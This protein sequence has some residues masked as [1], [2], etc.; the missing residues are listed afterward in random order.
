MERLFF[1]VNTDTG[2]WVDT[3]QA[4]SGEVE[5]VSWE[6]E[7]GDTGDDL[8][9]Y[10]RPVKSDTGDGVRFYTKANMSADFIANPRNQS[11]DESGAAVADF[12]KTV[13][14][15]EDLRVKV[16]PSGAATRG[17]LHVWVK[18]NR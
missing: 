1:D 8:E 12:S 11:D 3:S 16:L 14:S 13:F 6:V 4:V 15:G 2:A 9:L 10:I 17:K 5:Q 7:V 18:T